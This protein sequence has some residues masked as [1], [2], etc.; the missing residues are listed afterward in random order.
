MDEIE[1]DVEVRFILKLKTQIHGQYFEYMKSTTDYN[2]LKKLLSSGG[3]SHA[4]GFS[5]YEL[6]GAEVVRMK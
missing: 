2:E 3:Y 4:G 5:R 1:N 6:I